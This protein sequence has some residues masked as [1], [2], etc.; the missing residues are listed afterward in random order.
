VDLA[1][2]TVTAVLWIAA[3]GGTSSPDLVFFWGAKAQRFASREPWTSSS[4]QPFHM[5]IHPYYPPLVT[6][7]YALASMVAGRLVWMAAVLTFPLLLGGLALGRQASSGAPRRVRRAYSALAV[8][9]TIR[10]TESD[11]GGSGGMPLILFESFA[12]ALLARGR[13]PAGVPHPR[14]NPRRRGLVQG[15]GLPPSSQPP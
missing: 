3:T 12:I 15:G 7:V 5:F 8:A 4:W 6:N 9:A 10:R 13:R 11:V 14:R 2:I 1:F